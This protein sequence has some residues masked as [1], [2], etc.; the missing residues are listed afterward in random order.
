M[1]PSGY[2]PRRAG[3]SGRRVVAAFIAT[4]FAQNDAAAARAQ[5][6]QVAD[7]VRPKLP[8]LAFLLD[9]AEQ[10]VATPVTASRSYRDTAILPKTQ[11]T[12]ARRAMARVAIQPPARRGWIASLRSR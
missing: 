12:I 7:Q 10:D 9:A 1:I 11:Q 5:W 8:K 4:A 3:K 2:L 6:R